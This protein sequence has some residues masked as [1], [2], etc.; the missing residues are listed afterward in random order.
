MNNEDRVKAIL[1]R[2]NLLEYKKSIITELI[3]NRTDTARA[4]SLITS[5]EDRVD[6]LNN[7]LEKILE[8]EHVNV[9][10]IS[11]SVRLINNDP[12]LDAEISLALLPS[13]GEALGHGLPTEVFLEEHERR[14]IPQDV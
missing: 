6:T 7:E 14:E 12:M 10:D 11:K 4:L 5:F 3:A 2:I 1:F 9:Y 13:S 8:E